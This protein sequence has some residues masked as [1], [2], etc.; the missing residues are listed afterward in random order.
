MYPLIIIPALFAVAFADTQSFDCAMRS[1]AIEFAVQ[2]QPFIAPESLQNIADALNGSP[3]FGSYNCNI[4]SFPLLTAASS[5]R[6]PGNNEPSWFADPTGGSDSNNGSMASPF[7]SL[8][9]AILASRTE[10]P[11]TPRNVFLRA[12]TFYL[13]ASDQGGSTLVLG[14]ADSGLTIAAFPTDEGKVWISGAVPLP[15]LAWQRVAGRP[16]NVWSAPAVQLKA[17]WPGLRFNASRLISVFYRAHVCKS[18]GL[19]TL[20][21]R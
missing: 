19:C 8:S 5:P 1:L 21:P 15:S 6:L 16:G 9:R 3:E 14:A 7:R 10:R 12:G 4:T 18:V 13:A 11:G 2:I 17:G 20:P